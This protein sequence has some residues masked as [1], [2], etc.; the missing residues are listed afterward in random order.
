MFKTTNVALI[1]GSALVSANAMGFS[2]GVPPTTTGCQTATTF[3]AVPWGLTVDREFGGC[4]CADENNMEFAPD[5]VSNADNSWACQCLDPDLYLS[6]PT[7]TAA[8]V[9]SD[10]NGKKCG[11]VIACKTKAVTSW[12]TLWNQE[13]AVAERARDNAKKYAKRSMLTDATIK[14]AKTMRNSAT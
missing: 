3:S 12:T 14:R 5:S 6:A 4:K 10:N 13:V 1:A 9:I 11:I 2:L 7:P 8:N